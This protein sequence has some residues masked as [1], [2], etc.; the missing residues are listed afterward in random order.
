MKLCPNQ[1]TIRQYVCLP[2]TQVV[3]LLILIDAVSRVIT[4]GSA[5]VFERMNLSLFVFW[6]RAVKV[7]LEDRLS[8]DGLELG[9][10]VFGTFCVGG[11][12]G[13]TTRVG[14]MD[15]TDVSDLVSWVAPS[16]YC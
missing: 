5:L 6:K 11:R 1:S 15:V 7:L 13:A 9:L 10:E 12:V 16:R 8:L 3:H 14:H 2:Q 4:T